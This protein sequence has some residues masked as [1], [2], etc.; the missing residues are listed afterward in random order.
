MALLPQIRRHV[1]TDTVEG[2]QRRRAGFLRSS[3]AVPQALTLALVTS[4]AAGGAWLLVGQN[5]AESLPQPSLAASQPSLKLSAQEPQAASP[6]RSGGERPDGLRGAVTPAVTTRTDD[7]RVQPP[8]VA[9]KA[10]APLASADPG[11]KVPSG[12]ALEA[13]V[14]P[15]PLPAEVVRAA[16]QNATPKVRPVP[17]AEV[18]QL[19]ARS[20]TLISQGNIAGARLVLERAATGR[21]GEAFLRLAQTYDPVALAQW[22]AFGVKADPD[23]ARDLY[24]QAA[25]L[26]VREGPETVALLTQPSRPAQP[27]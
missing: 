9:K 13:A 19:I 4:L 5:Q 22:G 23:K 10:E 27:K 16:L 24:R 7:L 14:A 17:A 26:G 21:S 8:P 3:A 12:A 1:Q 6:D 2:G 20:G 25:D 18:E 15:G 11:S